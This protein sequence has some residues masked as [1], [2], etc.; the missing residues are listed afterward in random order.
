MDFKQLEYFVR[1]AEL[2]SFT[3]AS[4]FL[5]VA[6]SALSRQVRFLEVALRQNL[7]I[8]NGRGVTTT[9]A[10]RL[11]LD[12][13]LELIRDVAISKFEGNAE[14]LANIKS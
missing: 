11:L 6:Q 10:G 9:D 7:L 5:G 3:R 14:K 2:G 4:R 12:H 1:V 13:A 8:R